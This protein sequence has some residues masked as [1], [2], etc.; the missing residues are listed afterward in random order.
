L[1]LLCIFIITIVKPNLL[2][3]LNKIWMQFGLLLGTIMNPIVFGVIFFG[4]FTP[5]AIFMSL[6]GRDYL[7]LKLNKTDSHWMD[8]E[9]DDRKSSFKNQF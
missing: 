2:F 8:P 7:H 9:T 6:F 1:F 5:I 4:M 3:S